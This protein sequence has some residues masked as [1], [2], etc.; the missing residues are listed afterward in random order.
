MGTMF[1]A[2]SLWVLWINEETAAIFEAGLG[3]EETRRRNRKRAFWGVGGLLF[4]GTS[5][6]VAAV[7]ATVTMVMP[8]D[9]E[10]VAGLYEPI[11]DR[12]QRQLDASR[13]GLNQRVVDGACQ[14]VAGQTFKELEVTFPSRIAHKGVQELFGTLSVPEGVDQPRPGVIIVH[15]S[16]PNLRDGL[17]AGDLIAKY[18]PKFPIYKS[19]ASELA[20][21]GMVV[22]RYDKRSSPP[23][24]DKGLDMDSFAFHDFIDDAK[25]GLDFLATRPEVDPQALV[26]IGHSQGGQLAAHIVHGDERVAAVVLMGGSTQSLGHLIMEQT[27]RLGQVRKTRFDYVTQYLIGL[28]TSP[29][30]SCFEPIWSGEEF[31]REEDC[32]PGVSRGAMA[33]YEVLAEGIGDV[34]VDLDFPVM[35]IQGSCDINIDP[36]E[37]ARIQALMKGRDA[38]FHHVY[39]LDH[40]LTSLV[41]PQQPVYF[42]AEALRRINQFFA[43]VPWTLK[44]PEALEVPDGDSSP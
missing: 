21:Q 22:L 16:G 38:E 36:A 42:D 13:C 5:V 4:A 12:S 15:G 25:D 44:E 43:T 41:E 1:A 39:G 11:E 40:S 18:D 30:K 28:N 27:E 33:D 19:L 10:A 23:Y 8:L 37:I 31:D 6:G 7:V 32:L 35:A 17:S 20:S 34:L 2:Y 3:S 26:L 9:P 24:H 29:Y 14:A